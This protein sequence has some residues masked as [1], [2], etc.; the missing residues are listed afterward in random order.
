MIGVNARKMRLTKAAYP[1]LRLCR[2]RGNASAPVA[3]IIPPGWR[4]RKKF[5]ISIDKTLHV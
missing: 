3:G 2:R 1:Q 4:R 5:N